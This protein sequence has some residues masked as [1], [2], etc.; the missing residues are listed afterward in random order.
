MSASKFI[1][2]IITNYIILVI[3]FYNNKVK[4]VIHCNKKLYLLCVTLVPGCT[5]CSNTYRT[6]DNELGGNYCHA[7]TATVPLVKANR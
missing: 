7:R 1:E 5:Q 3:K 4:F 2:V 6:N